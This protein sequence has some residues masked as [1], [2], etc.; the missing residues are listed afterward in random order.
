[1]FFTN[2]ETKRLFLKNISKGDRDF[3]FSLFSSSNI[4]VNKYL[5]D[6]ETLVDVS[7]ADDI[8][9]F[10]MEPEPRYQHRWVIINKSNNIKMG[11]CGFHC[12][13]K[14]DSK[15]E[16]GYDLHKDF[17]GNG[18]MQEAITEIIKF[19]EK[20]MRVKEIDAHIYPENIRSIKLVERLGFEVSG[21][22][23]YEFRGQQYPHKIFTLNLRNED[24]NN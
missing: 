4:D 23:N 2:L 24:K 10:Y 18:Y 19:A 11:T 20:T 22:T 17:W 7:E 1:M 9:N 13:N 12:W 3:I 6:A 15:V 14:I 16:M 5:F 21:I 8:I